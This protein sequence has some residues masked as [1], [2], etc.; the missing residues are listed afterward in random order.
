MASIER[1]SLLS[2]CDEAAALLRAAWTPPCVHYSAEYLAWQLS[3]PGPEPL[4][5]GAVEV[6]GS[7]SGFAAATPRRL[8]LEETT[9]YAYLVSFMAVHPERRGEGLAARLYPALLAEIAQTGRPVISFA[10]EGTAGER[11]LR[12]AYPAAGWELSAL[13]PCTVHGGL[14]R[15]SSSDLVIDPSPTL[16]SV[17]E[18]VEACVAPGVLWNAP[19]AAAVAH[20][21]VGPA[22]QVVPL[23][24]GDG[25]PVAV[26]IVAAAEFVTSDGIS[27]A[28]VVEAFF[29]PKPQRV[30]EALSALVKQ[31]AMQA[32]GGGP[33]LFHNL[34]GA[35]SAQIRAAGLRRVASPFQAFLAAP[36]SNNHPFSKA[37]ATSLEIV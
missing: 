36:T 8:R 18:L 24:T 27:C 11:A 19:D 31:A 37:A 25:A 23:A 6:D 22:R 16:E 3:F 12:Q 29:C 30:A 4:A 1:L 21:A 26:G 14:P 34:Q 28:P 9:D 2:V 15:P 17:A 35:D 10:A 13:G 32:P 5:F 20:Y 33:V 7:L